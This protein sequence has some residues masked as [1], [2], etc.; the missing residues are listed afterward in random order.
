MNA[1][2]APA[3]GRRW[4]EVNLSEQT[5]TAWQGDIAVMHT[6]ISSGR[7]PT[8]TVTGRFKIG[9]KYGNQR[10]V[11]PGYDLPGVP[12]VMYF[13]RWLRHSWRL[14]AQQFWHTHEPRLCQYDPWRITDSLQ[15]GAN[16]H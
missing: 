2:A 3:D 16:R 14:L 10:V 6:Y 1:A 11:G 8:P 12:W 15:L 4:I 13:L 7:S 9:Q 5:L